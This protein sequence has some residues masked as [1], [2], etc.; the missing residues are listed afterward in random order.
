MDFN[1]WKDEDDS[2]DELGGGGQSED[3]EEV[4]TL[5][6]LQQLWGQQAAKP[7]TILKWISMRCVLLNQCFIE[8]SWFC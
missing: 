4:R 7:L 5:T 8:S 1:K 2:E 6:L 3:L